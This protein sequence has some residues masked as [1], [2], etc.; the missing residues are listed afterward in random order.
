MPSG[1]GHPDDIAINIC[2]LL[3]LLYL[4]GYIVEKYAKY[5][6]AL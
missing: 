2:L 5:E 6:S 1:I 3:A 4:Q